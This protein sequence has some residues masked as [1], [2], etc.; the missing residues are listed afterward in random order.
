MKNKFIIGF[1]CGAS[2]F[3]A[4]GVFAG[5]YMAT[6]NPFPVKLNNQNVQIE[7]YNIDGSTYFKLRD[8]ADVVGGFSVD[9]TNDT[10]Q[11]STIKEPLV[12]YPY[13]E[14]S[15]IPDFGSYTGAVKDSEY[16]SNALS[17]KYNK[18]F[19]TFIYYATHDDLTKYLNL[20]LNLGYE[21]GIDKD[22]DYVFRNNDDYV[23][24]DIEGIDNNMLSV[25]ITSYPSVMP[26]GYIPA[27]L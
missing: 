17:I 25:S 23:T 26:E 13:D 10:I 19:T 27:E 2:L 1:I 21:S 16:E 5:Q 15:W 3:G 7:G 8:I 14:C 20:M 9:F 24:I 4:A 12:Y 18:P 11:I 6:E 22:M